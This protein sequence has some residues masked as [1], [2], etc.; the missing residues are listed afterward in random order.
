MTMLEIKIKKLY[1]NSLLTFCFGIELFEE[2]RCH[3][4]NY[5][6]KN[7]KK[8][9]YV[10]SEKLLSRNSSVTIKI[11]AYMRSNLTG[12]ATLHDSLVSMDRQRDAC[13]RKGWVI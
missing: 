6:A 5:V 12:C 8:R 3:D 2:E 7:K 10:R 11:Y 1:T 4:K 9:E 13:S